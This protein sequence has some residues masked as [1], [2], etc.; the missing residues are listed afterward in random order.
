[1]DRTETFKENEISGHEHQIGL[2][3]QDRQTASVAI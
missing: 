1:M 3:T 2:N